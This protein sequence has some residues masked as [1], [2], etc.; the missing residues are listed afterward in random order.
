VVTQVIEIPYLSLDKITLHNL[1][2]SF[3][4][5]E[6]TDYGLHELTLEEKVKRLMTQLEQGKVKIFF[7]E[8]EESCTIVNVNSLDTNSL[9]NVKSE[10]S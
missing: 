1:V 9:S 5:R 8:K 7:D 10:L 2:E 3:V 6:G 4:L